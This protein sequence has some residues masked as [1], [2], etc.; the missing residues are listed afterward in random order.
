MMAGRGLQSPSP[1]AIVNNSAAPLGAV[2]NIS[3]FR[4]SA[5]HFVLRQATPATSLSRLLPTTLKNA[6]GSEAFWTARR[7]GRRPEP[8]GRRRVNL[9]RGSGGALLP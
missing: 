9:L 3:F 4:H 7:L 8:P 6:E 5:K 2:V 1:P